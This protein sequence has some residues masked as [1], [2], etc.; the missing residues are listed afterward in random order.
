M[1]TLFE[2]WNAGIIEWDGTAA[3]RL[4]FS[5]PVASN[6]MLAF[7]LI[8]ARINQLLTKQDWQLSFASQVYSVPPFPS[9][10]M[11]RVL[12]QLPVQLGYGPS[13]QL[14]K[15]NPKL[16]DDC[17]LSHLNWLHLASGRIYSYAP[18]IGERCQRKQ[19]RRSRGVIVASCEELSVRFNQEGHLCGNGDMALAAGLELCNQRS[20]QTALMLQR[21]FKADREARLKHYWH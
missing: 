6:E 5:Y 15:P 20:F 11:C 21:Y 8:S 14:E 18:F 12:S 7:F 4:S 16:G 2:C 17:V 13:L 19:L 1:N 10:E 3:P 9:Y